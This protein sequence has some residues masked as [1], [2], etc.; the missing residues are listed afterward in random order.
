MQSEALSFYFKDIHLTLLA[1]VLFF[2]TFVGIFIWT[3]QK[4]R[5]K[6]YQ[7]MANMPLEEE[8]TL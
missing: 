5:Q 7:Q 6:H 1:F 3:Y 4:R 2:I 8:K